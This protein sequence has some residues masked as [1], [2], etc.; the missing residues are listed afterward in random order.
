MVGMFDAP[1][2]E[3]GPRASLSRI[4]IALYALVLLAA[5]LTVV[6]GIRL[7]TDDDDD[8]SNLSSQTAPED[9]NGN[10]LHSAVI[11]AA[12]AEVLA[13]VNV[14]YQDMD[15]SIDAVRAGATGR[16]AKEYDK[17]L[18]GLRRLMENNESVMTGDILAAG[19]VFADEA[20]ARVLVATKGTV[21]NVSTG[22]AGAER[23]LRIQIDLRYTDGEWLTSDL[24]FVS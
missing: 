19:V 17:S 13:F 23:N 20:R 21:Q 15:A 7:A 14:D 2:G 18:E 11:E 9:A 22:E 24:Q 1:V 16:F 6:L 12:N 10:D 8:G 3:A 5:V 4:N